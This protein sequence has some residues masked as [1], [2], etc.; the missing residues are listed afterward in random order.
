M[1]RDEITSLLTNRSSFKKSG[2]TGWTNLTNNVDKLHQFISRL[3]DLL[4]ALSIVE[5]IQDILHPQ[6]LKALLCVEQCLLSD[7]LTWH[8]D[9]ACM[10]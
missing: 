4:G 3:P 7:G 1:P 10:V 8:K 6:Q 2:D 5:P 9:Y